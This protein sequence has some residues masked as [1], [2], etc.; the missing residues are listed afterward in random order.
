[1]SG[2]RKMKGS[3]LG[4]GFSKLKPKISKLGKKEKM[5]VKEK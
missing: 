5:A 2:G 4:H 1:M 3:K